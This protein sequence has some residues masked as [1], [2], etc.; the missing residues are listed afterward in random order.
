MW[1]FVVVLTFFVC[2][3]FDFHDIDPN[4]SCQPCC[5]LWVG[6]ELK[7][8]YIQNS[9]VFLISCERQSVPMLLFWSCG[10]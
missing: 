9:S 5:Y 2:F 8:E 7:P 1:V 3:S 10:F 6:F 4:P